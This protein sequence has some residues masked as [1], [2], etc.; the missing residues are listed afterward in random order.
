MCSTQTQPTFTSTIDTASRSSRI[1]PERRAPRKQRTTLRFH[2]I[3]SNSLKSMCILRK[4]YHSLRLSLV[5]LW[6]TSKP[7]ARWNTDS[8]LADFERHITSLSQPPSPRLLHAFELLSKCSHLKT[9]STKVK[10][11]RSSKN[12]KSLGENH[13]WCGRW[14]TY[15]VFWMML[16][17]R[18]FTESEERCF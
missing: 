4:L 16:Q 9:K 6:I 7:G 10:K 13:Q 15:N 17:E 12:A 11:L 14:P 1:R 3:G 5:E 2:K 8:S 18:I